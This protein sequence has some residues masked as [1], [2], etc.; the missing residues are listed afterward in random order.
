MKCVPVI[1]LACWIVCAILIAVSVALMRHSLIG[2]L[3]MLSGA[4]WLCPASWRAIESLAGK[5]GSGIA[6]AV[7]AVPLF[8]LGIHITTTARDLDRPAEGWRMMSNG[9]STVKA[10]AGDHPEV[11]AGAL[12]FFRHLMEQDY[13]IALAGGKSALNILSMVNPIER[14]PSSKLARL[15]EGDEES[16]DQFYKGRKI[17]VTG[18]ILGVRMNFSDDVVLELPGVNEL[19]NVQAQL[20]RDPEKFSSPVMEGKYVNLYCTVFGKVSDDT[21]SNV[22]LKDC[23][24]VNFSPEAK[25]YADNLTEALRGWL[26]TGGKH[27]FPTDNA[28][29]YFLVSYLAGT[30]LPADNPCLRQETPLEECVASLE[31]ME[32]NAVFE[33]TRADLP[34]WQEWLDLPAPGNRGQLSSR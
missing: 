11:D 9:D 8:L 30:K 2:G 28:A 3:L 6:V 1:R 13:L 23:T 17:I 24:E 16:I 32:A 15:Y 7:L 12:N 14:V 5:K 33:Q 27:I 25:A 10:D 22:Y 26:S 20:H 21:A 29:S 4:I 18:E 31:N 34:R 19:F